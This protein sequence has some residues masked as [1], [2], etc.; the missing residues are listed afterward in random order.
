M[1]RAFPWACIAGR[2]RGAR[3]VLAALGLAGLLAACAPLVQKAYQPGLGFPGPSL[4]DDS[5]VSFDGARLGLTRWLPDGE[6]SAVIV[7]VHGMNSYARA[8]H[9]AGPWWAAHGIAV[10]AYD[11]RGFGRSP[12]RGI[13]AGEPLMTEDLRTVVALIRARHPKATVAVVGASMGAAV[14]IEAFA[15]DRP[16]DA[17]RVVLVSPAVAGGWDRP[18]PFSLAVCMSSRSVR[19]VRVTP[20]AW[21]IA[22]LKPTDSPTE[23]AEAR[24]DPLMIWRMRPD[25]FHGLLDL[26]DRA[27]L[28]LPKVKAPILY[29]YGAR[30]RLEPRAAAFRAAGRLKAGDRSGYYADGWHLL[31]L[32]R[33]APRVYADVAAFIAD[34]AR[35]PPFGAPPLPRGRAPR[36]ASSPP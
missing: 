34:P 23:I 18:F 15:S 35:P 28:N 25:G 3:R 17:D 6:P 20:P 29:L 8:F 31:L 12:H 16:P 13:W 33:Q 24:A 21:L 7:A 14:V 2:L 10:Y 36:A 30:D 19:G 32:D 22:R 9:E 1:S 5:V 11:Q 26:A 27:A 4:H